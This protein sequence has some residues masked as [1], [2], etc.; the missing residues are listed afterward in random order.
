[1]TI[2]ERDFE[3]RI[4]NFE[5]D[6]KDK[7]DKYQSMK[8]IYDKEIKSK[9]EL[10]NSKDEI[11]KSLADGKNKAASELQKNFQK[12]EQNELKLKR[13]HSDVLNN[14]HQLHK[15]ELEKLKAKIKN[16][17]NDIC[18]KNIEIDKLSHKNGQLE[19]EIKFKEENG[20]KLINDVDSLNGKIS[21]FN[22]EIHSYKNKVDN[23]EI[24]IQNKKKEIEDLNKT[25]ASLTQEKQNLSDDLN[26]YK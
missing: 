7:D 26:K 19:K 18:N 8:Q 5:S 12:W 21:K 1:M 17:E 22:D 4:H 15:Q 11:I 13:E 25:I 9:Q 6:L 20:S 3:K 10:L 16:L 23:M 2:K 24:T 14:V